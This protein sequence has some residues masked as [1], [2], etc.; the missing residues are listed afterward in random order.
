MDD[1]DLK[2]LSLVQRDGRICNADI[3]R[4]IGLAPS[5][6]LE[7]VRKLEK[8]GVIRGYEARLNPDSV[9]VGMLAFIF[10]DTDDSWGSLITGEKL[11]EIPE[12]LEV[13]TIAGDE[14]YLLKVRVANTA[15]LAEF[16]RDKLGGYQTRTTIVLETLKETAALPIKPEKNQKKAKRQNK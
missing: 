8:H 10:V 15:A 6:T 12:V 9:G 5:A 1:I 13:H 14:C 7:R 3:A 2:I 16:L 4:D 11:A